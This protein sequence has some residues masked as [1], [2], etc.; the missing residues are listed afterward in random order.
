MKRAAAMLLVALLAACA[1]ERPVREGPAAQRAQ[2]FS[3]RER[4]VALLLMQAERLRLAGERQAAA[5]L[6][7]RADE[8]DPGNARAK[9]GLAAIDAA[10]RHEHIL[11]EANRLFAEGRLEEAADKAR[12]VLAEDPHQREALRLA[13]AIDEKTQGAATSPPRLRIA[14]GAPMSLDVHDLPV[15]AVFDIIART[16]GLNFVFDREVRQDQRVSITV[17]DAA[18]EDVIRLVL[19]TNQLEEKVITD[20]TVLV[21]PNTVQKQREYQEL[22][23]KVF[24]V[25]NADVKQ[26]ANMLRL[27]L[28]MRDVFVDE[29]LGMVV[30]KDTAP[31]VRLAER[32]IAA[33][34]LAEPEVMLDVEVLEVATSRLLQL[35]LKYP[36]SIGVG[37]SGSG[38]PGTLTL[39]EL[40]SGDSGLVQFTV[41]N[42]L[43]LLLLDQEDTGTSVLANPRIRVKNKDK[44]RIHIGDR[45]PVITTTAAATGGFV[46]ESVTYLDVGL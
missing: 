19:A 20:S 21:Y 2:A 22:V 25:G 17:R 8:V 38:G 4:E 46:S 11:G 18:V 39:R 16:A 12:L 29:K 1:S 45:V 23:V 42:P 30:V 34:D 43:F 26:T 24:Y 35:G 33:Q 27:M 32:L 44:A 28:K 31:M 41:S 5:Q 14:G 3:G 37:V 15:R 10:E 7:H 9:E 40:R 36:S 6:Y 13:R